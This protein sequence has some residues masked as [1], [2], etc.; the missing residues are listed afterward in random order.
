MSNT[1]Q[2]FS[3]ISEKLIQFISA[4]ADYYKYSGFEKL[5]TLMTQVIKVF[6]L[7][8]TAG[9]FLF[10]ASFWAAD[11]IGSYLAY[12]SLGYLIVAFIYLIG[13]LIVYAQ[14]ETW[15]VDPVI[16]ALNE[17]IESYEEEEKDH[18]HNA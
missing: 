1:T 7:F 6:I 11:F 10:F 14:R 3:E 13:G 18:H 16:K 5:A 2:K 17:L 8:I 12:H 9:S 4:K 15:I